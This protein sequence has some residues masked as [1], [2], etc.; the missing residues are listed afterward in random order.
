MAPCFKVENDEGESVKMSDV[1]KKLQSCITWTKKFAV[2]LRSL[3]LA[4]K[5]INFPPSSLR[6]VTPVKTRFV[7][8]FHMV[9]R[10][11]KHANVITQCFENFAPEK[12]RSRT[13][14]PLEWHGVAGYKALLEYPAKVVIKA[15]DKGHWTVSEA[16]HRLVNLERHMDRVYV[17]REDVVVDMDRMDD[18]IAASLMEMAT[19]VAG[20]IAENLT[21][22][23]D[24]FRHFDS[25]RP[26]MPLAV[27]LDSRLG[28]STFLDALPCLG[29][30]A[31][32]EEHVEQ[33]QHAFAVIE[34][35]EELLIELCVV[36]ALHLDTNGRLA[37]AQMFLI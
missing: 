22:F 21:K 26:H 25:T 3:K 5:S 14:T 15:K 32:Q 11:V 17:S 7:T 2:G 36:G 4:T 1:M 6:L 16:S 8:R 31:S 23:T 12:Y 9:D 29:S 37:P 10:L 20:D 27:L 28:G 35:H 33:Q 34:Q 18:S 19:R 30:D 24:P 13:P